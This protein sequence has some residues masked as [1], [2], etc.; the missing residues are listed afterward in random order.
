MDSSVIKGVHCW[1][2]SPS[3]IGNSGHSGWLS[4]AEVV[5]SGHFLW[6]RIIQWCIWQT[7]LT[8][9]WEVA[10]YRLVQVWQNFEGGFICLL[11]VKRLWILKILF[12]LFCF[13][14]QCPAT[15]QIWNTPCALILQAR[16]NATASSLPEQRSATHAL[17]ESGK[18]KPV[19]YNN[20]NNILFHPVA[21]RR[22]LLRAGGGGEGSMGEGGKGH[23]KRGTRWKEKLQ[24]WVET[25]GLRGNRRIKFEMGNWQGLCCL[26]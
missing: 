14:W 7:Q 16:R 21:R 1:T 13:Q 22:L 3:P 17:M 25:E 11:Q 15:F 9:I 19:S 12:L 18:M 6:R 20:N 10:R 24:H 23:S 8:I 26:N 4:A 2:F 5:P